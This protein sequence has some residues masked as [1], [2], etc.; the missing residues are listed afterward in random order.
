MIRLMIR[1]GLVTDIGLL[2]CDVRIV[3]RVAGS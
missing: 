1:V 2:L 3:V